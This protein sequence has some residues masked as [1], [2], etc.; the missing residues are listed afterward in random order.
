MNERAETQSE[1]IKDIETTAVCSDR[2]LCQLVESKVIREP[3]AAAVLAPGRDA[4]TYA[5]LLEQ[6]QETGKTL[7]AIGIG[8]NDPVAVV[9]P[10]GPEMALA[11]LGIASVATCAPLNPAYRTNEFD[12]YLSDLQA[13]ALIVQSG[14]DSEATRVAQKYSIPIIELM[15][16][17]EESAGMFSLAVPE[18]SPASRS[19]LAQAEDTALIL[20]T[21][22]TTSRPKKV[23]LSHSQ[24]FGSAGTIATSL[25]LTEADRCLN[26]MPLF[27][28]HGLVGGVLASLAAGSS[29]VCTGGFAANTFFA[30]LEKF[31]PSWYTAVPAVHQAVLEAAEKQPHEA[32]HSSLRFIR[33]CSAPLPP[34]LTHELEKAF[35]I[36]VIE[37]YG[38][39]EA[40]HQIASNPLPPRHRKAGSVGFPTGTEINI[41]NGQGGRLLPGEKGEILI[42]GTSVISAYSGVSAVDNSSFKD[43]WLRTGDQGYLDQDGY[44]FI[45]G[46]LKEIV[47]RGGEKISLREVDEALLEHPQVSQAA[48]FALPHP[49][50]GE[51]IAAAVIVRDKSQVAESSLRE[52]LFSRLAEFKVPSRIWFVDQLPRTATGKIRRDQLVKDLMQQQHAN[53][54][55]ANKV[56]MRVAEIYAEVLG[57]QNVGAGDNF[58]ALGGDSLRA[59]Q[60]ISRRKV[61]HVP[62]GTTHRM[63][64][65]TLRCQRPKT[66]GRLASS[67]SSLRKV[68]PEYSK[69]TQSVAPPG[70]KHV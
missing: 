36:P 47:N 55:T 50:L 24:L 33:S 2:T 56:E 53:A 60:V 13:K 18:V 44:L 70:G 48:A 61:S 52:H 65:I 5:A 19:G 58:F 69:A 1:P 29:V 35:D 3:E 63:K 4:L 28:V 59:T 14:S 8:R 21:S 30:F 16:H 42:R 49:S 46:R 68:G 31:R 66:R 54:A 62:I 12:F 6:M 23:A 37:A 27:H 15:P 25:Q 67:A 39:T 57:A 43:G 22:G 64:M 9:L 10:N 7:H 34:R 38:M 40:G 11:F 20:H 26:V 41:I 17:Q 45:S 32:R 51:E